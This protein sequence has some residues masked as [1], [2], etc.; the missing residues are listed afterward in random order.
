VLRAEGEEKKGRAK[1]S[2][3]QKLGFSKVGKPVEYTREGVLDTVARH[4]ACDN[5][6]S[7][8]VWVLVWVAR[9]VV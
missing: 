6:V 7:Q 5:Q 2:G 4:V 3:Q 1:K 9:R 8:I